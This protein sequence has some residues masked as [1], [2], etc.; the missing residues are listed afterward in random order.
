MLVEG[1]KMVA[2]GAKMGWEKRDVRI[3]LPDEMGELF[4]WF[5]I[6]R[7]QGKRQR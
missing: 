3:M 1:E 6:C 2:Q 4:H 5:S 7:R